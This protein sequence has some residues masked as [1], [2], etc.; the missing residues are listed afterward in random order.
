MLEFY[1]RIHGTKEYNIADV[2]R[3]DSR[4]ELLRGREYRGDSFLIVL[5][6]PEIHLSLESVKCRHTDAVKRIFVVFH[7]IDEISNECCMSLS[8]T[9]Y[10]GLLTLIYLLHHELDTLALSY[11]D[12][13]PTRMIEVFFF[14]VFRSFYLSLDYL[15]IFYKLVIIEG[16]LDAFDLEW[17]QESII[18][19]V[20]QRVGIDRISEIS[21]GLEIV[22]LLRRRCESELGRRSE[23]VENRA[24]L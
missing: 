3:I 22:C 4:R 17:C 6:I 2:A 18:D 1:H 20:L 9:E 8:S 10:Y 14:I 24:P 12:L 11:L 5:E 13:N 15:I 16:G 19:T 23:V 7:L 21:I